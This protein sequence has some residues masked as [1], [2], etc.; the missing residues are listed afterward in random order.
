MGVGR[1]VTPIDPELRD[2]GP[3]SERSAIREDLRVVDVLRWWRGEERGKPGDA[4]AGGLE[5]WR[6][7][8]E[9]PGAEDGPSGAG[10]VDGW[11]DDDRA[12]GKGIGS[13]DGRVVGRIPRIEST[14]NVRPVVTITNNSVGCDVDVPWTNAV[15]GIG[16]GV[17]R[18]AWNCAGV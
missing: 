4:T 16:R 8:C 7:R 17:A 5:R 9:I 13:D 15:V 12:F 6:R 11:G 14:G 3:D 18:V 10:D 1:S 2:A